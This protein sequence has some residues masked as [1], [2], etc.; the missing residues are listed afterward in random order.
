M[1]KESTKV[2]VRTSGR[3]DRT[4]IKNYCRWRDSFIGVIIK[5]TCAYI[6]GAELL[7]GRA[8]ALLRF[9]SAEQSHDSTRTLYLLYCN[10]RCTCQ[11]ARPL[12]I[13]VRVQVERATSNEFSALA[14]KN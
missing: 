4:R 6:R 14:A 10:L 9:L 11:L 7:G 8:A 12:R 2:L 13:R 3:Y 5:L 1:Q